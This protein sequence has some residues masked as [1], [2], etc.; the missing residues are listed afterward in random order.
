M[1]F[2][3][4]FGK[5]ER[6]CRF[7]LTQPNE[8]L[9]LYHFGFGSIDLLEF[10]QSVVQRQNS[11]MFEGNWHFDAVEGNPFLAA[12]M[13]RRLFLACAIDQYMPHGFGRSVKKMALALPLLLDTASEFQP[14]F[15]DQRGGLQ[16]LSWR[17]MRQL[18]CRE[19]AQFIVDQ[20]QELI[21]CLRIALSRKSENSC[22]FAHVRSL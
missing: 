11:F 17:L 20:R 22:Y 18:L 16:G 9:Q 2:D 3:G 5:A 4:A 10:L 14:G 1:P 7:A 12:A 8:E 13:A 6:L 21:G 15:V 19:P